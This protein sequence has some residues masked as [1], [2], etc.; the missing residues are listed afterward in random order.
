M[1]QDD[2]FASPDEGRT[3]IKPSPGGHT[4]M[5]G[6]VRPGPS[7]GPLEPLE[8]VSATGLNPLVAAANPLLN[9][10]PQLRATLNHPNPAALRDQ[11]A[12]AIRPFE[13]RAK[14]SGVAPEKVIAARY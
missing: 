6:A 9:A 7:L 4:M 11:L 10:V 8:P 2:P 5:P 12:A 13:A 3:V 14:A 1:N